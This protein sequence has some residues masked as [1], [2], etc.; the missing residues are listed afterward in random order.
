[1]MDIREE[2]E[3]ERVEDQ[4]KNEEGDQWKM[5]REEKNQEQ[6]ADEDT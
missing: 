3:E 5:D 4:W 2:F 6:E 1:M